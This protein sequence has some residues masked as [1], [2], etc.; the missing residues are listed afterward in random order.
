MNLL[1]TFHTHVRLSPIEKDQFID[2]IERL[3]QRTQKKF[4]G[5]AP[6]TQSEIIRHA[7]QIL[8]DQHMDINDSNRRSINNLADQLR[9]I[10]NNMNQLAYAYNA[11]QLTERPVDGT[12]LF[13]ELAKK[14]DNCHELVKQL[15]RDGIAHNRRFRKAIEVQTKN[16]H[17]QK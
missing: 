6:I 1:R 7:I 11:G 4:P 2:Y 17:Q 5:E 14:L 8:I 13:H 9:R 12:V 10:G 16:K 3:N 15:H